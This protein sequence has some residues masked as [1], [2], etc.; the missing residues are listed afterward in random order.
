MSLPLS[1]LTASVLLSAC[2]AAAQPASKDAVLIIEKQLPGSFASVSD[3]VE[4]PGGRVA[5]ANPKGRRFHTGDFGAGRVDTLGTT[6]DTVAAGTPASSHKLPGWVANL[7][8]DTV[9]IVDFAALR[10][11]L[12]TSQGFVRV[13]AFPDAGG[14][15]PVLAY[16]AIGHGYK[17]D[18]RTVLGGAEPGTTMFSD[19]LV[20]LRLSLDGTKVDTVAR[21]SPP[22]YGEAIFG[23]QKQSVAL[24]FGPTDAFGVLPDG[25]VW[26]ARA[27]R[28]A[29]DWRSPD[30]SWT[31]GDAHAWSKVPVTAK[32][33][34]MVM[35]R[36]RARGL[37]QG[38]E[39]VFPFADTK[40]SFEQALGRPT[41]EVWLQ[42]SRATDE[43]PT[44][45]AV[46]GRDGKLVRDVTAPAGVLLNGLGPGRYAYGAMKE[47]DGT[48]SVVRMVIE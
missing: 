32:D 37:P 29:V 36:L 2:G 10:T 30:G 41:G 34:S 48:R 12:W 27:S 9:A 22:T 18:F 15:T 39:V 1:A 20:V 17:I 7:A 43:E 6:V 38:V 23:E 40:P 13:L 19:S 5:F 35:E 44:R 11:T 46:F 28:H 31:R 26:V 42:Y 16:D 14:G 25:S 3:V 4:L 47:P 33:K 24:V 8:G 21:M 45:Y